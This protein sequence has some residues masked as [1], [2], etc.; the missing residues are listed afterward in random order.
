M[1]KKQD[2]KRDLSVSIRL[3]DEQFNQIFGLTKKN[4]KEGLIEIDNLL[5]SKLGTGIEDILKEKKKNGRQK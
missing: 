2:R 1:G 3:F 5:R 4:Y